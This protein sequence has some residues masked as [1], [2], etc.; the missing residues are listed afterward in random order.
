MSYTAPK[1]NPHA[2]LQNYLSKQQS[3]FK[4]DLFDVLAKN[5]E[6]TYVREE[7]GKKLRKQLKNC[8]NPDVV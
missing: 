1:V 4:S 7:H 6:A 8:K 2:R 3:L 5:M